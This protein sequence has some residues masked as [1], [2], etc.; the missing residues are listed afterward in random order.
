MSLAA[1]LS[2]AMTML[3]VSG[4]TTSYAM[5][6]SI[7]LSQLI[8][9]RMTTLS[10]NVEVWNYGIRSKGYQLSIARNQAGSASYEGYYMIAGGVAYESLSLS[11]SIRPS[12]NTRGSLCL[13]LFLSLSHFSALS[14]FAN[15]PLAQWR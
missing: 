5:E 9:N 15:S 10:G 8:A 2:G 12:F 1:V 7:S 14:S 13:S 11:L 4:P 6:I 3:I